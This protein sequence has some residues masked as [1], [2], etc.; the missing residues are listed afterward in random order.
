MARSP[1]RLH[2]RG[3]KLLALLCSA[4]LACTTVRTHVST[5]APEVML[6]DGHAVVQLDLWV[7]SNRPLTPEDEDRY[8]AEARQALEQAVAGRA[9]A[10]GEGALVVRTLGVTR[11][12]GR[13][14]DQAG[15]AVGMAV[16]VMVIVAVVVLAILSDGKGGGSKAVKAPRA[17]PTP[18][19]FAGP[20]AGV[21]SRAV[22]PPRFGSPPRFTTLP[23]APRPPVPRVPLA[24]APSFPRFPRGSGVHHG[25][26]VH[27]DVG[28]G[29]WVPLMPEPLPL[30]PDAALPP[31]GD[32]PAG[33]AA[34]SEEAPRTPDDAQADAR[35]EQPAAKTIPLAPPEPLE[36]E[37][38]GFW[39]GDRLVLDAVMVD[40]ETG[41]VLWTKRVAKSVDPRNVKAVRA[42]V[43]ELF[44]DG[45]WR[46]M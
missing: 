37:S 22:R 26:D 5:I 39:D 44:S 16:G 13:R 11:T 2:G 45:G 10:D 30:P 4:L 46:G 35:P 18:P 28:I 23:R 24:P 1:L 42:A 38:R 33:E 17:A 19:R 8:R 3:T 27:V 7:E 40:P 31:H 32:A 29:W 25:P 6:R 43:D 12:S 20:R 15:A 9:K 41:E 36:V 34:P 21:P 14:G